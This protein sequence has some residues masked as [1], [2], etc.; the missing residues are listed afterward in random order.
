MMD[1]R[2]ASIVFQSSL[3]IALGV[4]S[5]NNKEKE[6]DV[7]ELIILAKK[8]ALVAMSPKLDK[9]QEELKNGK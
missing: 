4:M 5:H 6:I 1:D 2:Q 7:K 8:L 3:K 9:F